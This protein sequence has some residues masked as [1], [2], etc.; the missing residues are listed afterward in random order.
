M[1]RAVLQYLTRFLEIWQC[2]LWNCNYLGSHFKLLTYIMF[3]EDVV[4]NLKGH[5]MEFFFL[6]CNE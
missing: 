1:T 2:F 5:N 6:F 4:M 3:S